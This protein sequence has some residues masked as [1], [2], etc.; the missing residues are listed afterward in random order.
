MIGSDM[1]ST[2]VIT[3]IDG[4]GH[5]NVVVLERGHDDTHRND[6]DQNPRR[7]VVQVTHRPHDDHVVGP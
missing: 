6:A 7:Y 3:A 2:G 5:P 1:M 4:T